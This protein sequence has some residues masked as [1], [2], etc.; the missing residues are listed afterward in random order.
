[1]IYQIPAVLTYITFKFISDI[2]RMFENPLADSIVEA[3]R[4][5]LESRATEDYEEV[6]N[7]SLDD[8]LIVDG[9]R[10]KGF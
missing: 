4:K 8:S 1:M 9:L 6:I 10:V 2:P 5:E 7:H 3:E